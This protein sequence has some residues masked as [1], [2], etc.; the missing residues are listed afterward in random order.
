MLNKTKLDKKS[1]GKIIIRDT[2]L[3][4][5]IYLLISMI[6]F[7]GG[8][9]LVSWILSLRQGGSLIIPY[10]N[11]V[12]KDFIFLLTHP[13]D[14]STL[15]SHVFASLLRVIYGFSIAFV[16]AVPC[17]VICAKNRTFLR[18]I[19]PIIEMF[20]PIPPIAWIPFAI[21]TFGL[22]LASQGFIIFMGAF[23]PIFQNI[24]DGVRQVNPL[25]E[26]V[27][28]SLGV[29]QKNLLWDVT[30]PSIVP[31]ILTGTRVAIGV[32]WMSVIAAEMLGVSG[33]IGGIGY[34][35]N[36]MKNIGNYSYMIAG[37]LMIALIGLL[38]NSVFQL[39]EKQGLPWLPKSGDD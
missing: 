34:F 29:P 24:F 7:L 1:S 21:V 9:V 16:V 31:N 18:V 38:L 2:L 39:I 6:L 15:I 17:G 35:I 28:R 30:L 25:Y 14:G 3:P 37:M 11:L 36:F 10:P 20:R 19:Q 13:I 12:L 23:F 32:G 4:K 5:I 8:W 33:D 26:D 22:G 27:A